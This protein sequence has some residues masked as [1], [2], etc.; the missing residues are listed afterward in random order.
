[1]LVQYV[2]IGQMRECRNPAFNVLLIALLF[3][4]GLSFAVPCSYYYYYYF[5]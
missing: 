5:Q 3:H 1:M 4:R 2:T